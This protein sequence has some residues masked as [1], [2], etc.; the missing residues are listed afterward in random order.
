MTNN[1]A[2][3]DRLTLDRRAFLGGVGAVS[4]GLLT[5]QAERTGAAIT[6]GDRIHSDTF[7]EREWGYVRK[8]FTPPEGR[9]RPVVLG[10]AGYGRVNNQGPPTHYVRMRDRVLI[11]IDVGQTRYPAPPLD[12]P[13]VPVA[14]GNRG[15]GCS[16][17]KMHLFDRATALDGYE[18]IEWLADRPWSADG[19]GL[20]GGSYS[21]IT[22]FHI[23]STNPPSLAAMSANMVIADLYRGISY[24]GGV[25]NDIFPVAWPELLRP[26][27]DYRNT[28]QS[29][30]AGDEICAQNIADRQP[31][32]PENDPI[33]WY[34]TQTDDADWA[35][36]SLITYANGVDVPTYI[37]HAWQDEQT[38][39]R[40]GIAMYNAIDPSP[41]RTPDDVPGTGPP[42]GV[43][44]FD[45]QTA[46]KYLRGTNGTHTTAF[47]IALQDAKRWFDYWLRGKKSEIADES[48]V[49]LFFGTN[50]QPGATL[51]ANDY[52]TNGTL[53]LD[54]FPDSE[55][56][57]ERFY[58]QSDGGMATDGP[59]G[60]TSSYITGSPRKS[61]VAVGGEQRSAMRPAT[62]S[63]GAD[64]LTFASS[65]FDEPQTIAG[66]IAAKLYIASTTTDMDLFVR[67]AD[68]GPDGRVTP[69][70]RGLLRAS[71]RE[72]VT[73]PRRNDTQT[74]WY[75]DDGEIIRPYHSHTDPDPIVPG[76]INE[77]NV[78]IWPLAH[79][80]YPGHQ[81]VVRIHTPP[82][83]DGLWGYNPIRET[84]V[85]TV[86]HTEE[87]PSSIIFPFVDWP[88]E[89]PPPEPDCGAPDGYRCIEP[90]PGI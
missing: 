5:A 32:N 76:D 21:G 72:L 18:L 83:T 90:Q 2:R 3:E 30:A 1:E 24:P 86:Y 37:A 25:P 7:E 39:P 27:L 43:P 63:D 77:Y 6:D 19:V 45:S 34:A 16:G 9:D 58:L 8:D 50:Q 14:A 82:L 38:G 44:G 67:V 49:R 80:V 87:Y 42:E 11:G 31:Q 54:G 69:L 60:G 84:G 57:W 12:P 61:W 89:G 13:Y 23:A 85:N 47:A 10:K 48:T 28:A 73:T 71:H 17:G 66:P 36:H 65:V 88:G 64:V 53:D 20:F 40:G 59:H 4:A 51:N 78:E 22:A 33:T 35:S 70:Q 26:G 81:I 68:R 46:P 79:L 41:I 74:T 15:T 29:I 62:Q 75:S 56:D 52:E 55:T